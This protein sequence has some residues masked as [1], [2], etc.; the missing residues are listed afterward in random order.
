M[1]HQAIDFGVVRSIG[2]ALP[3][4]EDVLEPSRHGSPGVKG[5]CWLVRP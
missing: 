4:I 2:A 1:P 5:D 3:G